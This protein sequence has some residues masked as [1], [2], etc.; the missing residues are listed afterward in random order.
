MD[1]NNN[2]TDQ[3]LLPN[4][5]DVTVVF[6]LVLLVELFALVL[7]LAAPSEMEGFW[8]HLGL[9]SLFCQ[10]LGLLNAALLC[11][12]RKWLNNLTMANTAIAS[13]ALVMVVCLALSLLVINVGEFIGFYSLSDTQWHNFFLLKNL[14][15]C[16]LVYIV[17]L[18]YLY[19]QAQW[20]INLQ[21]QSHAQI[22][23]LKARIRPH[24]L[25][26]S[27]NTIASLIQ[28][29]ANKAEKA[30]EDLSDMF[31][32]SLME[33]TTH[34]L[35]DEIALTKSYLDIENLRLGER[36]QTEWQE[37]VTDTSM[38]IPALCLQPLVENAIYHGIEPL[39]QGG[40]IKIQVNIENNSLC[41][42]IANP[43]SGRSRMNSNKSNHMAQ[44]NIRKRLSL[45]YGD[46]A[47]FEVKET[48]DRYSVTLGIP[49]KQQTP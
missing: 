14:S 35:A 4:F 17:V 13:F 21:A 20:K 42:S 18:R 38:E 24:F 47:V 26:N 19:I 25:F 1:S 28:I 6:M 9:I 39:E 46:K 29:D 5:C 16:A 32:A 22:Q 8:S 31:R 27:M 48:G 36:L 23:A 41:L 44:D 34:S 3:G 45:L 30:V 33:K 37:N 43:V 15:I 11:S 10:W 40:L 49:V 12:L 2:N 7:A